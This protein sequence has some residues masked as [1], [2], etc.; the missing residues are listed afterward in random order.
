M[1]SAPVPRNTG[2][3]V[4][5]HRCNARGKRDGRREDDKQ[6]KSTVET[7]ALG[8]RQ[9]SSP[10]LGTVSLVIAPPALRRAPRKAQASNVTCATLFFEER[11]GGA[12]M[13]IHSN[14]SIISGYAGTLAG[15]VSRC[16]IPFDDIGPLQTICGYHLSFVS[17]WW[18]LEQPIPS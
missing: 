8:I 1:V 17:S 9:V 5:V 12:A 16:V 4:A 14:K 18:I 10:V 7:L 2:T 3:F 11:C 15:R 6:P 13:A